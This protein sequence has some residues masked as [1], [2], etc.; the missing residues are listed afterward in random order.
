MLLEPLLDLLDLLY[1]MFAL[2]KAQ[3]GYL[4]FCTACLGWSSPS[5]SNQGLEQTVLALSVKVLVTLN[6]A[7]RL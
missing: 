5:L 1:L 3:A 2:F 6:L 7:A 4:H